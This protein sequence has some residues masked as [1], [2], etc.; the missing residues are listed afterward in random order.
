MESSWL[1]DSV[2]HIALRPR[3]SAAERRARYDVR[4]V[5]PVAH[6]FRYFSALSTKPREDAMRAWTRLGLVGAT[7][8]ALCP[9]RPLREAHSEILSARRLRRACAVLI[10]ALAA[11]ALLAASASASSSH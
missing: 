11:A 10:G 1:V 9:A 6:P 4:L 3:H 5:S 8:V 2:T 7:A